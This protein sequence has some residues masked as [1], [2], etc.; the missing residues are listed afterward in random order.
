MNLAPHARSSSLSLCLCVSVVGLAST[1]CL[2]RSLSI[3]SEPSGA[4]LIVNGQAAG[5]TP[6]KLAFHHH[7]TYRVELRKPGY[8]PVVEGLRVGPKIYERMPID[9][10]TDV[11]WPG[12]IVDDRKVHYKLKKTPPFDKA[13]TLA[14]ARS[15]A[16]EAEKAI[17]RLHGAAPPKRGAK[18]KALIHGSSGPKSK[19]K[20]GPK[21]T[22]KPA[23]SDSEKPKK[24]PVRPVGKPSKTP[25]ELDEPPD[26]EE[27]EEGRKK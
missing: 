26:V 6:A 24:K 10:V 21:S 27:I 7:G 1:G 5:N 25:D 23:P 11:L 13:K 4:Q 2:Q 9:L 19:P 18:D 22:K 17:P 20:P 12:K 15:A 16:A 8:V 3:S 14:A